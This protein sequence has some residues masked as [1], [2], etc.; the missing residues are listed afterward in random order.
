MRRSERNY[1]EK[2]HKCAL[3]FQDA[4]IRDQKLMELLELLTKRNSSRESKI[5]ALDDYVF[6]MFFF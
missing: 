5:N 4:N 6:E 2:R 3:K 1:V